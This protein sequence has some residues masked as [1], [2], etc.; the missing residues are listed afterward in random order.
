VAA[1]FKTSDVKVDYEAVAVIMG[2]FSICIPSFTDLGT[3]CLSPLLVTYTYLSHH[4]FLV[5]L[6]LPYL[7]QTFNFISPAFQVGIPVADENGQAALPKPS[8][9]ASATSRP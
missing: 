1:I 4:H 2:T 5:T 7:A 3:F 8:P 6:N 9:T